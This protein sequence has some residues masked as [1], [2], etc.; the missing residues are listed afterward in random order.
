MPSVGCPDCGCNDLS[1]ALR[2]EEFQYG[3]GDDVVTL[4]A[5]VPI[6]SCRECGFEFTDYRAEEVRH[7]TVC[8]HLGVLSPREIVEIRDSIGLTRAEFAALGGFGIASLQRWETGTL[9]QNPAN[10]RLIY[11]LQF[12]ANRQRLA[13]KLEP[14]QEEV[15]LNAESASMPEYERR[16]VSLPFHTL[17]T[18]VLAS[19]ETIM[20]T[21]G[22]FTEMMNAGSMFQHV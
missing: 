16:A 6:I 21:A 15:A 10:D 18:A 22:I 3:I 5:V 19:D 1:E 4:S 17:S 11:L 7:E 20:R 13:K 9:V 12:T 8:R 2:T 14:P